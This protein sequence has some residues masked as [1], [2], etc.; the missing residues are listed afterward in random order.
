MEKGAYTYNNW[1][2]LMIERL[3]QEL[4]GHTLGNH[5]SQDGLSPTLYTQ[6]FMLSKGNGCGLSPKRNYAF[7]YAMIRDFHDR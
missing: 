2:E 1:N 6:L 3:P 4:E 5:D 7:S